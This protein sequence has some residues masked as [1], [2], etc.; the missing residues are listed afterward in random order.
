ML[1]HF[2][3]KMSRY[4]FLYKNLFHV[5]IPFKKIS[6]VRLRKQYCWPA[7]LSILVYCISLTYFC[8]WLRSIP[9]AHAKALLVKWSV[10]GLSRVF[11]VWPWLLLFLALLTVN[12][13]VMRFSP[14]CRTTRMAFILCNAYFS[15]QE[16]ITFLRKID[17]SN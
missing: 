8:T 13:C 6:F 4:F 9:G 3:Q 11:L 7:F 5:Q 16:F 10:V 14:S 2:W 12:N 17:R 1:I 15:C